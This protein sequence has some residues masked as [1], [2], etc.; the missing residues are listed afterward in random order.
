MGSR[1]ERRKKKRAG[2]RGEGPCVRPPAT[3]RAPPANPGLI[4]WIFWGVRGSSRHGEWGALM[5]VMPEV[6]TW[7]PMM[8]AMFIRLYG[9]DV[10]P[11]KEQKSKE[12]KALAAA[13]SSKGKK[14]VRCSKHQ[15]PCPACSQSCLPHPSFLPQRRSGRRES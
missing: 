9:S 10:Q 15:G 3:L 13:N 8:S 14:K 7:S 5:P 2:R 1:K 6:L 4:C 12:A 11:P